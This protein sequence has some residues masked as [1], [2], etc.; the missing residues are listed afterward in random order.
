[1]AERF[2]AQISTNGGAIIVWDYE[3]ECPIYTATPDGY[4]NTR[5]YKT[6][7]AAKG[8][9]TIL[10]KRVKTLVKVKN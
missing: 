1:M 8:Q 7:A 4:H 2:E 9:A 5:I 10:N 3:R 6:F